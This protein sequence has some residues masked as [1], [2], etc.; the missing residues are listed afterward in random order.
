MIFGRWFR[1]LARR[2][3]VLTIELIAGDRLAL[4]MKTC[5]L[6][7][8]ERMALNWSE[9]ERQELYRA[10]MVRSPKG[11]DDWHPGRER[12]VPV[13]LPIAEW[14]MIEHLCSELAVVAPGG[15]PSR[16]LAQ[17]RAKAI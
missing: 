10:L 16:V 1:I 17:I 9:D 4:G 13:A 12:L 6:D 3:Q 8:A 5:N 7:E 2:P 11:Y 14:K 15:W